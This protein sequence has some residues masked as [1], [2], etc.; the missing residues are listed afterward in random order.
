MISASFLIPPPKR[1]EKE[2]IGDK[3]K[4][5]KNAGAVGESVKFSINFSEPLTPKGLEVLRNLDTEQML[6]ISPR[7][8][9]ALLKAKI[10]RGSLLSYYDEILFMLQ[11]Q[12]EKAVINTNIT[13]VSQIGAGSVL[14]EILTNE[15][16][17]NTFYLNHPILLQWLAKENRYAGEIAR[18]VINLKPQLSDMDLTFVSFMQ[19]NESIFKK[20]LKRA[21]KNICYLLN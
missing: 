9:L 6:L 1:L 20:L 2:K 16:T 10:Y 5:S 14:N 19:D 17:R 15:S 8:A 21:E 13:T 12:L 3:N 7:H 4:R 11:P 18:A